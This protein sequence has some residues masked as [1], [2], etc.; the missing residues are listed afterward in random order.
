MDSSLP[1][2]TTADIPMKILVVDDNTANI[3]VLVTLLEMEGHEMG[4]A[5]S[6]EMAIRVAEHTRPD[7]ILLDV[8]MPDL[9]GYATCRLL[10]ASV[11]TAEIPI[12][13]VTAKKEIDDIVQGFQC[14]GVDYI[15]KPFRKEEVVA[16]VQTHLRLRRLDREKELLI[17]SL[18]QAWEE[19]QVLKGVLPICSYCKKIRNDQGYWDRIETYIR[20]HSGREVSHGVCPEC[21]DRLLQAK[22]WQED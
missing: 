20:E 14:G 2:P 9:D 13:F 10:K 18:R 4:M 11:S 17:Q 3:D 12:I 22:E 15:T 16:R 19:V 7:L 5:T 6:G 8:M 21:R 1:L